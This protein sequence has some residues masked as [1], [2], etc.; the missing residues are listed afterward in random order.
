MSKIYKTKP[1]TNQEMTI[2]GGISILIGIFF[3]ILSQDNEKDYLRIYH[4]L[5]HLIISIAGMYFFQ[6]HEKEND[7]IYILE[8]FSKPVRK[9]IIKFDCDN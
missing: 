2:K 1:F 7:H 3:F 6:T 4:G 9:E 8:L 5:W